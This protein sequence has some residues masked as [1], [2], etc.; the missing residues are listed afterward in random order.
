MQKLGFGALL[1]ALVLAPFLGGNPAGDQYGWDGWLG[2]FRVLVLIAAL[3][4]PSP[5]SLPRT[6]PPA[7]SL[8]TQRVPG[9]G[10]PYP[11]YPP[12]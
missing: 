9:K 1:L 6:H 2:V 12:S 4:N 8:S 7:P 5:G 11:P 3:L 10:R